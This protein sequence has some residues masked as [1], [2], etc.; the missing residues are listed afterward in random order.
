MNPNITY[1]LLMMM[2]QCRL[3]NKRTT[4]S[5][6]IHSRGSCACVG[7]SVYMALC[8]HS[9]AEN[10]KTLSKESLLIKKYF[11]LYNFRKIFSFCFLQI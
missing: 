7:N 9:S 4:T 10:L 5:R 8:A 3:T 11:P 6:G 1:R 2:Y